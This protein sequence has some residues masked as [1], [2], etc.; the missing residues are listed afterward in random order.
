MVPAPLSW[1]LRTRT[2]DLS[3]GALI[4]VL[5]VTPDSFSDGGMYVDSEA[6]IAHGLSMTDQGAA[7]VD[8]GGE[9]TRP[10]S[11]P[12]PVEVELGRVLP[13]VEGLAQEG[14]AVSIDTWKPEVAEAALH[15]GAEI[16]ND[17]RA[18]RESGMAELVAEAGCGVIMMHMQG[19]P[20]DMQLEPSY[21]DVV[22]EVAEFLKARM[23]VV[24]G[25]GLSQDHI[26]ID[27]GIGFGKNLEH[28]LE[29]IRSL[30]RLAGL[31]PV[32]LG[33]SRKTFL[34]T[35]TGLE[36][37]AERD[38]ATAVIT[39]VGFLNG[40][41]VFR[42]HDVAGSQQALAIGVAIVADKQWDAW[43]PD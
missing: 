31:A 16:V 25:A 7:V 6:A 30:S 23:D 42:V 43:R 35:L 9:S 24:A 38:L 10:G 27:P 26:A 12:V 33:A 5:N 11:A 3:R 28:N 34:G 19:T 13:V 18:C 14:I 40:A 1:R 20:R 39:V 2:I 32:V 17:V 8:V 36:D 21:D 37:P 41:R 4:G 15:S 29:L 22:S